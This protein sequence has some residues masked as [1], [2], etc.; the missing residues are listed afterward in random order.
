MKIYINE[1]ILQYKLLYQ[2]C[3][4]KEKAAIKLRQDIYESITDI[5]QKNISKI[6]MIKQS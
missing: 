5:K 1:I 2:C 4:T 3:N 6:Y